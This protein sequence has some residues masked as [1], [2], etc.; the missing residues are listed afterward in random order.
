[1]NSDGL[2][3]ILALAKHL[4]W[5]R[6]N[7]DGGITR[8]YYSDEITWIVGAL[9]L[10]WLA[11]FFVVRY[12]RESALRRKPPRADYRLLRQ[13]IRIKTEL[14]SRYLRP[15]F[16]P[17]VHA[18]GIGRLDGR[19]CIQVFVADANQETSA[20]SSSA[21]IPGSHRGIPVVLIEMPP[22]AFLSEAALSTKVS[23]VCNQYPEGI[24][25]YQEVIV[26]GISGANTKLAGQSGTIGY[27]CT[28]KSKLPGRKPVCLLSNAHVFA[29]LG[30]SEVEAGDLIMQP[31]PGE[32]AN[33]RPVGALVTFSRLKFQDDTSE[34][35]HVDAAIARLWVQQQHKP[36]LP[37]IGAVKGYV[38]TRDVEVGEAARKFGRTTG[39][40]EGIVTSIYL[41]IRIPY[42]RAGRSAFFKNQFLIEPVSPAYQNFVARGDSGSLLLDGNQ[43][44]IGLVFAGTSAVKDPSPIRENYDDTSASDPVG[45]ASYKPRRVEGYGVANPISEVLDRLKI[46]LLIE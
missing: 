38:L 2:A 13:I 12:R 32:P 41:D 16:S 9:A 14:S 26:G 20:G 31:S 44:A 18:V 33:N 42:E 21:P 45:P 10:A 23:E 25:E 17:N 24:R 15:G 34:P 11:W 37:L 4:V 8:Y 28:R 30:N 40:T 5:S 43:H 7:P 35:N 3:P 1:M 19:Y 36:V 22:A 39:Y 27:F 46:D 29:D 6:T